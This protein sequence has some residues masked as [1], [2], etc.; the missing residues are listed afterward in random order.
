MKDFNAVKASA[1]TKKFFLEKERTDSF[2]S[3]KKF[4]TGDY[5]K[6]AF[7]ALRDVSFEIKNGEA[8]ALTGSN[9]SGKTTL[10]RI[11][12]GILRP[13]SG[14]LRVDGRITPFLGLGAALYDKL[15]VEENIGICAAL[16]E[17]KTE[18]ALFTEKILEETGL[19]RYRH[20]RVSELSAG[21]RL[22]LPFM[23]GL[24]SGAD[25]F[26]IDEI[27]A[28]GDTVFRQKCVSELLRLKK[29]GKTIIFSTHESHFVSLLA[30]KVITLDRGRI[31]FNGPA[32][33]GT[34][35]SGPMAKRDAGLAFSSVMAKYEALL[36]K[37][38]ESGTFIL[39]KAEAVSDED[40][41]LV[42]SK[43]WLKRLKDNDLTA[44]EEKALVLPNSGKILPLAWQMAG[45][46]L[47]ASRNALD[48]GLGIFTG[49]GGHHALPESGEGFSPVNDIAVALKKLLK[50]GRIKRGA[51]IDLDAH[52]GNGTA[53][54]FL[55]TPGIS[56]YSMHMESGYPYL[57][58]RSSVD[59]G[60]KDGA[61][62]AE[63]L[64]RMKS[65]LGT[66]L[67]MAR[68]ELAVY[69]A[70]AD[71]YKDDALATLALTKDGLKERD[72]FVFSELCA[73]KIPA[74]VVFGG[75]Y[76]PDPEDTAEINFHTILE[77]V[78]HFGSFNNLIHI[79]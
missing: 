75:G 70:G 76:S 21:M 36:R 79:I 28:V 27:L 7:D 10:L 77:A 65:S 31:S 48:T 20:A 32:A 52:Q 6:A 9:G 58:A 41:E 45:G 39:K 51:V 16:F 38:R 1:I 34:A 57:R 24:R 12:A 54:I 43:K 22:R 3:L 56:T 60:L 13:T 61:G 30:D 2:S 8:I 64:L 11:L 19:K 17:I 50:E 74:C 5:P 42:H 47:G 69:V 59:I 15:T 44:D 62:D 35:V 67:D 26:I 14:E 68:P 71:P 25:I 78:P 33:L 66:F 63:Y 72:A 37:L 40:L 55:D 49:G 4:L 46:T 18:S 29:E 53:F 23:T 73:R